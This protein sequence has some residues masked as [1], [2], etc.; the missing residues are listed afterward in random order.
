MP[1]IAVEGASVRCSHRLGRAKPRSSRAFLRIDGHPVLV[2]Q[3]LAANGISW[4]PNYGVSVKPCTMTGPLANGFSSFVF[5]DGRPVAFVQAVGPTDGVP[6][7]VTT[8][9]IRDP[10]Q[11]LVGASG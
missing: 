6:P 5:A 2:R 4:C 1:L 9:S 10:G 11:D 8:Y 7:G 3:D